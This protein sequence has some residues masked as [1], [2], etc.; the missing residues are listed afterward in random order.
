MSTP[1]LQAL[2]GR[3]GIPVVDQNTIDAFV[4]PAQGEP[5]HALLFFSGQGSSQ[6]SD[7]PET[8][9]VAVVMPQL[10]SAYRGRLR[11]AMVSPDSE[12][13]LKGRFTVLM[14][15][16]LVLTKGDEV[17]DVFPKIIDWSEYVERIERH[18]GQS[19]GFHAVVH[20]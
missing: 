17:L 1:A 6:S 5:E 15:P 7:R 12:A 8:S 18:L 2:T 3:H 14:L 19:Q 11:G 16:S 4:G 10:L 20:Q 9:D 13:A